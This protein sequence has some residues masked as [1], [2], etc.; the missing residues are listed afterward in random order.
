MRTKLSDFSLKYHRFNQHVVVMMRELVFILTGSEVHGKAVFYE[1]VIGIKEMPKK[2]TVG[3][4]F[5]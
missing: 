3:I 1:M 4:A 5:Q 2:Q